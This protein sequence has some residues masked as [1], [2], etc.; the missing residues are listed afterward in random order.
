MR[1]WLRV[2]LLACCDEPEANHIISSIEFP[3]EKPPALVTIDD[4]AITFTGI[5]PSLD[6]IAAFKPWNK[7]DAVV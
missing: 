5:F 6:D 7:K 2:H 3:T 1:L 4:R